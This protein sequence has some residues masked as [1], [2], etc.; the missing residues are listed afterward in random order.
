MIFIRSTFLAVFLLIASGAAA[1]GFS[2]PELT[3][4]WAVGR[5]T[6]TVTDESRKREL[7]VDIWYPVDTADTKA[8]PSFYDLVF[9]ALESPLALDGPPVSNAVARPLVIFSHGSF[10]IRFQSFFLMEHLASHGYVVVAP[11]HAGNTAADLIFG[12]DDTFEQIVVDRPLDV[13]FLVDWMLS[14]NVTP[15]DAFESRIDAEQ[16][17]V[18]GHSFGGF[19][20]I[21][22]AAGRSGL[23]PDPR[24]RVIVP[25]APASGILTDDELAAVTTPA[26]ILGGTADVTTPIDP[27]SVRPF[28]LFNALRY[29][30]DILDAGHQSFTNICI[31]SSVLI[32]AG[33]P[34]SL[35]DFLLGNSD[36]G[37]APDLIPIG[38]AQRI[39]NL[40]TTA[41]LKRELER[42][43][44]YQRYLNRGYATSKKLPVEFF[45]AR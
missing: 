13:R 41:F 2:P 17:A 29:R 14:R 32:D 10:G 18:A 42:E 39:T 27:Q 7:T 5:T 28:E 6:D 11:D 23:A 22:A 40:Y 20:A 35:I 44:R 21:A 19:T 24:I 3:G 26:L 36:E 15:G 37:C 25:M 45:R 8:G 4:P 38:E 34:P 30:V 43:G 33:I 12:T 9:A 16:I 31:F 1:T